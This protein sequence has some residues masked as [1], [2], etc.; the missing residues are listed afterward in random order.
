MYNLST[1]YVKIYVSASKS[2]K[3]N[4]LYNCLGP[5]SNALFNAFQ[6]LGSLEGTSIR[7]ALGLAPRTSVASGAHFV[8]AASMIRKIY[9]RSM[10]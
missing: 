5:K 2:L 9:G 10:C 4:D 3:N 7:G 8:V 1:I 6:Q